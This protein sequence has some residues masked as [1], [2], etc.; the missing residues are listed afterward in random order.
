M[1]NYYALG[2][3]CDGFRHPPCLHHLHR[4][5]IDFRF[6]AALESMNVGRLVVIEI[7][8]YFDP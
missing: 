5:Q 1:R 7:N 3:A 6:T 4:F 8:D 2:F